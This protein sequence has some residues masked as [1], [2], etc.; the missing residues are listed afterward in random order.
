MKD[1]DLKN[2]PWQLHKMANS[3]SH[4]LDLT[5]EI[6]SVK[7]MTSPLTYAV[8]D[9]SLDLSVYAVYDGSSVKFLT[10]KAG[11]SGASKLSIKLG[12]ITDRQ[13]RETTKEPLTSDDISIEEIETIEPETKKAL[14]ELGVR[15]A[16]DVEKYT[17]KQIKVNKPDSGEAIDFKKLAGLINKAQRNNRPPKVFTAQL[18]NYEGRKFIAIYGENLLLNQEFT[19]EAQLNQK[20]VKV[21]KGGPDQ[22]V[23]ELQNEV[24]INPNNKLTVKLDEDTA[25]TMSLKNSSFLNLNRKT[26]EKA[27]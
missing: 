27:K 20:P 17:R 18:G 5:R 24:S 3:L 26:N 25:F 12:S 1:Q 6:L 15:S 19:A 16:K 22:L 4:E 11:D 14:S 21:L 13:I 10:A 2:K 7:G 8:Q 23:L 9:I